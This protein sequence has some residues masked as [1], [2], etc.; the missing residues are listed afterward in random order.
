MNSKIC[1]KEFSGLGLRLLI[2]AVLLNGIQIVGQF[3][4]VSINR[5]WANNMDILLAWSMIPQYVLGYPLAFLIMGRYGDKRQIVRHKMKASHFLIAFLMTYTLM[6]LGNLVGVGVTAGIG[7]LKGEAV[8]NSLVDLVSEGNIWIMAVYVVILAPIC[9]ELLF[10]KVLCDRVV[11]YGQGVTVMVSGL[12]FGLAHGNFNQFFYAFLIGCF[13]AFLYVKTGNIKYTIGLHMIVNFI[14]SVVGGLLLQKVDLV[15]LSNSSLIIYAL[16]MLFIF[17]IVIAGAVMFLASLSK[18]KMEPGEITIVKG[19][20]F[21][22]VIVNAGMGAYCIVFIL[23]M[24][25]QALM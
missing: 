20:R 10:R 5:E 15:H 4:A 23:L 13:F 19:S 7:L 6:M 25:A 1:E 16:Y 14:G 21:V 24:I 11:K 3:V 8:D 17:G 12:M 2:S 9:E 22:T 18:L